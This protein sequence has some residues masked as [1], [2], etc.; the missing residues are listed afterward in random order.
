[1][2]T[3]KGRKGKDLIEAKRLRRGGKNTQK[4]SAK[5]K[6]LMTQI[7][8]MMWSFTYS[9]TSWSVKSSGL[10][11]LVEVMEFQLSYLIP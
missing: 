1:M 5:K 6:V 11:K 3:I 8:T 7:T 10:K 9:Q 2:D 4:N